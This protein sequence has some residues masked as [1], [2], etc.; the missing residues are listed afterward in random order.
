MD[1]GGIA[2]EQLKSIVERV[3]RLNEEIKF[4]N[5]A[6]AELFAEAKGVGFHVKAIKTIIRRRKI[7]HDQVDEE[8]A[9]VE[10]YECA[11]ASA[12]SDASRARTRETVSA[13]AVAGAISAYGT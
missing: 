4:L 10:L 8:D 13:E 2:G 7:G 11:I 12:A 1:T 3:E 9:E 5:E 6:K